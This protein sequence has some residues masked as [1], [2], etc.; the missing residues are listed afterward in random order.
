MDPALKTFI[1]AILSGV[2]GGT[3]PTVAGSDWKTI[4]AS[5]AACAIVGVFNLFIHKPM[6]NSV[7]K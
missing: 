7:G 6:N 4:T 1:S 3:I 2:V 5:A